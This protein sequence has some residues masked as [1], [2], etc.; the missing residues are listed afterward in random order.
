MSLLEQGLPA[1]FFSRW[2]AVWTG[3]AIGIA[4]IIGFNIITVV[5][6]YATE[7]TT[8]PVCYGNAHVPG[9]RP[10]PVRGLRDRGGHSIDDRLASSLDPEKMD[11]A[12]R[13]CTVQ[14]CPR[15]AWKAYRSA[16]FWYLARRTQHMSNLYRAYGDD[17]LERARAI[18]R[19]P[20]DLDVEQGLRDRYQ[21][22]VFRFNDFRQD[23][24]ALT[25]FV[26]KG[27]D[28]LRPCRPGE[29]DRSE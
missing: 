11:A 29:Q 22:G 16:I 2:R 1:S 3:L 24:A 7:P 12:M 10:I 20:F 9:T 19:D 6:Y 28:A 5:K 15:A 27:A 18:Y 21:A 23:Q 14:S 4:A 8:A 13:A 26:L 17:G 25:I